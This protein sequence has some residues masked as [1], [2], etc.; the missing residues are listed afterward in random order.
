MS[1]E[2]ADQIKSLAADLSSRDRI[3]R[4]QA[5]EA[6]VSIGEPAFEPLI[7]AMSAKHYWARHEAALALGDMGNPAAIPALV[8]ALEDE[9]GEVRWQASQS[10]S[11]FGS[12]GVVT[13]L[14]ELTKRADSNWFRTGAH[15]IL[16]NIYFRMSA[17]QETLKPVLLAL[18]DTQPELYAP[19][20][21]HAAL[22]KLQKE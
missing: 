11:K 15:H 18:E 8:K 21:A 13:L 20:A 22:N 17:L 7:A 12:E 1:K 14:Q 16:R 3:I 5:R 6:L 2:Q 9:E 19:V 10:L 4:E